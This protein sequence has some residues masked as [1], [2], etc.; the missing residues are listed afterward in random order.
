MTTVT[1][2]PRGRHARRA[3]PGAGTDG[4]TGRQLS[5]L[6]IPHWGRRNPYC[7]LL[8][9]ALESAGIRVAEGSAGGWLPLLRAVRS[10]GVPDVI[11]LQ[12]QHRFFLLEGEGAA[13]AAL[14]TLLFFAQLLA[15][16]LY[17]VR[18]VWTV[19]NLVNHEGEL[20]RL[21]M[22]ACRRLA[23]AVDLV[24]VHCD[25]ARTDVAAAY[26]I[27][28]EQVRVVPHGHFAD[29]FPEPPERWR[30]RRELGLEDGARVLLHFGHIRPYKGVED[31][32]TAFRSV[33]G[34]DLRLLVAGSPRYRRLEESLRELAAPDPR[35]RLDLRFVPDEELLRYLAAADAV[36]LPYTESL[37]SGSAVLGASMSRALIAPRTGCLAE[38]PEE[39]MIGY[40]TDGGTE[41][42]RRALERSLEA[43]LDRMGRRAREYAL[44]FGWG[45]VGETLAGHYRN[46]VDGDGRGREPPVEA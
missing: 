16:R 21:E 26:G 29:W 39:A 7:Q 31:L 13:R 33:P 28:R 44:G 6:V 41:A 30:A 38:F 10:G 8:S 20:A 14:R 32:L 27:D 24:V 35:I 34:A 18:F 43:P 19:H 2:A 42:L 9:T 22:W 23:R 36:V 25:R 15:L 4:A 5:T 45:Q 46:L 37:T 12:W 1:A 3:R 11:H 17:G 40:E